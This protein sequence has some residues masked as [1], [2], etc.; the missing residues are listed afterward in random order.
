MLIVILIGIVIG[1]LMGMWIIIRTIRDI[2][3]ELDDSR[4]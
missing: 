4:E 2:M 1:I 3:R